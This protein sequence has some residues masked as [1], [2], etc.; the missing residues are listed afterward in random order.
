[1]NNTLR[2]GTHIQLSPREREELDLLDLKTEILQ[3][4]ELAYYEHKNSS[5]LRPGTAVV[6][7][8]DLQKIIEAMAKG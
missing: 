7:V 8:S 6:V 3:E 2:S 1:M 5:D 4:I